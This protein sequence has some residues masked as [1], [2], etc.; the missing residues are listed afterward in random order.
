MHEIKYDGYR[1]LIAVAGPDVKIHSRSGLDWTH[2]FG[3]I[4]ASWPD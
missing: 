3:G 1:C 2:R 4:A